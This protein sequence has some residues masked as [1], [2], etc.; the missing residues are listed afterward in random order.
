MN[1]RRQLKNEIRPLSFQAQLIRDAQACSV[2]SRMGCSRR[3]L[4]EQNG[5]WHADVMFVAEAPGRLGA[6]ITGIPLFGD[7]TGDRFAQ[8]LKAMCWSRSAIFITN[9]ILC[10]PRDDKGNNDRPT[11]KEI[12][13]CSQLLKR[14]LDV[15]NPRLVVALG[16]V[17]LDALGRIVEHG[18]QT[19]LSAG[20]VIPW[21]SRYLGVLYHPGPR[22]T[23]HRPWVGQVDDAKQIAAFADKMK[24][25]VSLSGQVPIIEECHLPTQRANNLERAYECD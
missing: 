6:E 8:L 12:N 20:Q 2:C 21:N 13:N 11:S 9:A 14:T 18:C 3:V 16:S 25:A 17:A 23:I 10:N 5:N 1:G 24:L 7:R 15:V 4:T 19:K 22:T